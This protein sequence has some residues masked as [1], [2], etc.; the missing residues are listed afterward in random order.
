MKALQCLIIFFA[1]ST[2]VRSNAFSSGDPAFNADSAYYFIEQQLSFG[3]RVPG[4]SGHRKCAEFIIQKLEEYGA[5]TFIQHFEAESY[6]GSVLPLT[7][8]VGSFNPKAAKRI[9]L[10]AHWDTRHVADKDTIMKDLPIPGANDG[11]SGVGVLLEIARQF[12]KGAP[13]IGVDLIFFDG[14]DQG[15]PEGFNLVKT[16]LNAGKV[17]WCLGSQ[18]WA[19]NPHRQNYQAEFGI[20]VDMAG[21][22]G[23]R[24]YKEGGSMQFAA[25]YMNKVW[26]TARNLEYEEFFVNKRCRG[27][28]DD[29]IFVS[30]VAGIPM[31]NI[32]EYNP[33]HENFFPDYHHTHRDNIGVIDRKTLNAVGTTMLK[34][35][36]GQ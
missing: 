19:R 1:I 35:I 3:P 33:E 30:N 25:K 7:N 5:E 2:C 8:I 11:A 21:G 20:L 12:S 22:S 18:Y 15:E 32:I 31:L 14:E 4:L 36:D 23:A 6:E 26:R 24:F 34:V 13:A 9:L 17:W 16:L 10:G 27:I 29:H 28:M